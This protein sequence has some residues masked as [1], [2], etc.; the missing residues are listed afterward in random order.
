ME[1][2]GDCDVK[3]KKEVSASHASPLASAA[4]S[5][6]EARGP[7]AA[8][9]AEPT[10]A[11]LETLHSIQL[12]LEHGDPSPWEQENALALLKVTLSILAGPS[13]AQA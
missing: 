9:Q 3:A 7:P 10:A 1:A 8:V 4:A 5:S 2:T 6:S 11:V 13:S 12:A